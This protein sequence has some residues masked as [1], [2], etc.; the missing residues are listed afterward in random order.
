[1]GIVRVSAKT[2]EGVSDLLPH[3]EGIVRVSAKTGEG[4]SDLLE[5]L[6]KLLDTGTKQVTLSIPYDQ[7]GVLDLLYRE[8]KVES[9]EYADTIRVSAV[10]TPKVLGQVRRFCDPPLPEA[11]E[12]WE[13]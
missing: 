4:V 9:V 7:G 8:A 2:G 13:G 10:C 5:L 6:C 11:K 3:G 1:E 12:P